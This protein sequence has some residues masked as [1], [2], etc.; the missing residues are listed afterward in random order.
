MIRAII[1]DCFGVLYRD[2]LNLLYDLVPRGLEQELQDIIHACDHGFISRSEYFDQIAELTGKTI[3]DIREIDRQKHI[4]NE[5]LIDYASQLKKRFKIGLLSNIGDETMDQL[6]P[7]IEREK[8]F[9]AFVLSS[10]VGIIKPAVELFELTA[11]R[12]EVMPHECVMI[13]DLLKNV[14]GAEQAGMRGIL[15]SNNRQFQQ[16]LDRLLEQEDA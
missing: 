15:F 7:A 3:S 16:D 2:Q 10:E 4:R 9:D 11:E 8:L 14:D 1:F 12:L 13:D 5:P 6:F